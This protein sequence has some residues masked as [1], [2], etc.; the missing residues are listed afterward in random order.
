MTSPTWVSA[1]ALQWLLRI[2]AAEGIEAR[3]LIDDE[4]GG[5]SRLRWTELQ[6]IAERLQEILG[7]P[8]SLLE[9][10]AA[11]PLLPELAV[12]AEGVSS[13]SGLL[14]VFLDSTLPSLLPGLSA[15]PRGENGA[16][17]SITLRWAAEP[18]QSAMLMALAGTVASLPTARGEALATVAPALSADHATI[19]VTLPLAVSTRLAASVTSAAVGEVFAHLLDERAFYRADLARGERTLGAI[20]DAITEATDALDLAS[21]VCLVL[22]RELE[23]G[24]VLLWGKGGVGA[25]RL[26]ASAGVRGP[27]A[28][29]VALRAGDEHL[30]VLELSSS[31]AAHWAEA[32]APWLAAELRRC[33]RQSR[34]TTRAIP[35]PPADWK[36]T[37]RQ[38]DVL[39]QVATGASTNE[40]ALAL[41]SSPRTVDEHV[42]VCLRKASAPNRATLVAKLYAS[43]QPG[44]RPQDDDA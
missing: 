22:Q 18:L 33:A 14:E 13:A 25:E 40:V 29:L 41:G 43:A 35:E 2:A 15:E 11:A 19:E 17:G 44:R 4:R 12:L 30:G 24:H 34:V 21:R 10:A 28:Q 42:G 32:V 3:L 27:D 7:G 39:M 38:R 31:P 16:T 8:E 20:A 36:L 23:V 5:A 37:R 26:F 6:G 1:R 9:S